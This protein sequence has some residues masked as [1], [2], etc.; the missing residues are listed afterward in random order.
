MPDHIS[1]VQTNLLRT[2]HYSFFLKDE[3]QKSWKIALFDC[4]EQ[5]NEL[6]F[7]GPHSQHIAR[8][9]GQLRPFH[10]EEAKIIGIIRNNE[11]LTELSEEMEI[12]KFDS[13]IFSGNHKKVFEALT[14]MEENN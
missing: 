8:K 4:I 11:V 6:F 14:W 9:V 12:N 2:E 5:D 13:L 1:R 10:F 3:V 7:I